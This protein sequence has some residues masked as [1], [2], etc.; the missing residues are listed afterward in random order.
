MTNEDVI[1]MSKAGLA[2]DVI[3]TAI[4]QAPKRN[5]DLT[6]SGLIE[7]KLG[8]VP[9]AI[10]R[11]MQA[12]ERRRPPSPCRRHRRAW[13]RLHPRRLPFRR[14]LVPARR[15]RRPTRHRLPAACPHAAANANCRVGCRADG[16][17][18]TWRARRDCFS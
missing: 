6:A 11:A 7:L 9:D 17:A 8:K 16:G 5:F 1:K 13:R 18:G 2:E 14:R 10:V 12:L 4:R 3:I 15:C